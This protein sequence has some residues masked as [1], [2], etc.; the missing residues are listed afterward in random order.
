MA[1]LW[2]LWARNAAA[3]SST[4]IKAVADNQ[5]PEK[6]SFA[7]V[8]VGATNIIYSGASYFSSYKKNSL[9]NNDEDLNNIPKDQNLCTYG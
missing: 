6:L 2:G 4:L 7:L 1:G 8:T 3:P 9:Q 5:F